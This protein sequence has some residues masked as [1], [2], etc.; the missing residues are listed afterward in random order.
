M[1]L[2]LPL[3]ALSLALTATAASAAGEKATAKLAGGGGAAKGTATLVQTD[4]GVTLSYSGMG[5]PP[6]THGI[7]VHMVGQCDGP[8]FTTAG[9]HWNP[10]Q[11]QHGTENPAGPH[12]GDLQNLT[13]DGRGRTKF[14]A[15]IAG[16]QLKGGDN[17][18][19]DA[20]GAALVIHAAAD[21]YKTDPSGNSGGRIAC[22]VLKAK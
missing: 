8:D 18:M 11:H 21:D 15:T 10:T 17:P 19:I 9:S 22:G 4:A 6:G 7:H 20:D 3:I 1:R 12:M 13:V 16:A 14:S 2:A 5:L